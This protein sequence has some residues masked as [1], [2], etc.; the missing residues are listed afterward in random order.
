VSDILF[1]F[2]SVAL[3]NPSLQFTPHNIENCN[4]EL[5]PSLRPVVISKECSEMGVI[6]CIPGDT[7]KSRVNSL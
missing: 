5:N 1:I 6:L 3:L 7:N 2:F 4:F